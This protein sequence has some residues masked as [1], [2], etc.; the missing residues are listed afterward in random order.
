MESQHHP[1]ADPHPSLLRLMVTVH[2]QI[3][4]VLLAESAAA[5]GWTPTP[6]QIECLRALHDHPMSVT[7]LAERL[8]I[9]SQSAGEL[10][11]RLTRAG[12][13]EKRAGRDRRTRTVDL[14]SQG[15]EAIAWAAR[16]LR[17]LE[18]DLDDRTSGAVHRLRHALA[19]V[20]RTLD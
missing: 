18:D 13:V 8:G 15:H 11:Q 16:R 6:V 2:R 9:T 19:E 20:A 3:E 1:K 5:L 4:R 12:I 7:A 10:V 14:T 17:D